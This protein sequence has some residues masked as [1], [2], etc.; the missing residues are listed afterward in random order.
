MA[1]GRTSAAAKEVHS[2][3][4]GA[5]RPAPPSHLTAAQ[6]REWRA[7]VDRLPADWFTRENH[8]LLAQY[9]RH[10]DNANRLAKAIAK[11]DLATVAGAESFDKLTRMHEREGRAASSLATRMRLTQQSRYNAQ[12]ANTAAKNAGTAERKPWES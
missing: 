8:A 9:C 7:I 12:S 1:R 5:Q 3:A 2:L 11:T 10:V 6:R 4:P